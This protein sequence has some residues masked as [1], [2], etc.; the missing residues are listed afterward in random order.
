MFH[1]EVKYAKANIASYPFF[2][3]E[4]WKESM[5]KGGL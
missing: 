5:L 4:L 2:K 1:D 3:M